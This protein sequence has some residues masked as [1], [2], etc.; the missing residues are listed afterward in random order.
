MRLDVYMILLALIFKGSE[1]S[2]L[3]VVQVYIPWTDTDIAPLR[4]LV[5]AKRIFQLSP[6]VSTNVS[7]LIRV[8]FF[9]LSFLNINVL[10]SYQSVLLPGNSY[11]IM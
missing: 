8:T 10:H 6:S 4:Q 1:C 2:T 7:L 5:G 3:Q 11:T 9:S